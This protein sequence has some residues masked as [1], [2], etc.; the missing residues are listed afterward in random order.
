MSKSISSFVPEHEEKAA[1]QVRIRK[2]LRDKLDV[3]LDQKGWTLVEFVEASIL[4]VINENNGA[5]RENK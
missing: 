2:S 4:A 5:K 1:L 3:F